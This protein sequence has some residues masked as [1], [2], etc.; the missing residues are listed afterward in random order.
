MAAAQ[1]SSILPKLHLR[2]MPVLLMMYVMAFL[3]RANVSFA[4]AGLAADAGIG[5]AAFA[6]G[7]SIFFVGYALLEVPSNLALHRFG[8]R[9]WM[10][11]IMITWGIVSAAN[12][13]VTG[14]NSFYAV[15]F[16]LGMTEA[17]FFPGVIYYMTYWYPTAA[18][19]RSVGLFYYGAPLALTFGGPISGQL[20]AHEAFGLHGWQ[21]MFLIE[22]LLASLGGVAVLFLLHDRPEQAPWLNADEKIVLG[23]ALA[24]DEDVREHP[25]V[26]RALRDGRVLYL[27]LVYFLVEMGFYGLTFYL[28][29]QVARL[30]GTSIGLEVGLV[31]SLPWICALIA[32]TIVPSWCDARGNARGIGAL[33]AALAG[34]ALAVSALTPSPLVALIALCVAAAGLIVSPAL[35]W[36]LP[37]RLLGGAAA[38]GGIALINSIG[39]LGG[40]AAPNLR[41]WLEEIFA[42]NSAGLLGLGMVCVIGACCFAFAPRRSAQV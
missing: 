3:D 18:R 37:T 14:P 31:T 16:L 30:L 5:N 20:V 29:T 4:K 17:G 7:A 36:T 9:A 25:G 40:F 21:V 11:R 15:R 33:T 28:P 27:A 6:F 2:L 39:N 38:A 35:F 42:N 10:A 41:A 19:A 13:F 24:E 23:A 22:G 26:L 34:I 12:A 32:V 1:L 8:A